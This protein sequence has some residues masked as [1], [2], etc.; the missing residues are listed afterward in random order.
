MRKFDTDKALDD[1]WNVVLAQV[2]A[3]WTCASSDHDG[4]LTG[5]IAASLMIFAAKRGPRTASA[6]LPVT[7]FSGA[8][9][10]RPWFG[11]RMVTL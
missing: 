6:P 3:K 4:S 7:N 5:E 10:L 1:R 9:C 11:L 2:A 8:V